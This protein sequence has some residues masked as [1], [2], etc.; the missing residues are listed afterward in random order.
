MTGECA[1]VIVNSGEQGRACMHEM[2]CLRKKKMWII[3]IQESSEDQENKTHSLDHR[4]L[5][6]KK[7]GSDAAKKKWC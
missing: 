6:Q 1:W 5:P 4:N 3:R 2:P 7:M